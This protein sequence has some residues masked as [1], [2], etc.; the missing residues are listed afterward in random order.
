MILQLAMQREEVRG[1]ADGLLQTSAA[2]FKRGYFDDGGNGGGSGGRRVGFNGTDEEQRGYFDGGNGVGGRRMGCNETNGGSRKNG[3]LNE[4]LA[5]IDLELNG[6]SNES[7]AAR[8]LLHLIYEFSMSNLKSTVMGMSLEYH[9][10]CC[11]SFTEFGLK[12]SFAIAVRRLARGQFTHESTLGTLCEALEAALSWPFDEYR[13]SSNDAALKMTA[14]IYANSVPMDYR[15]AEQQMRAVARRICPGSTWSQLLT[16]N[17]DF[18]QSLSKAYGEANSVEV[19]AKIRQVLLLLSAL[20]GDVFDND[21][22]ASSHAGKMAQVGFAL[23]EGAFADV[24]AFRTSLESPTDE[25]DSVIAGQV[26][27]ACTIISCALTSSST[28][29]LEANMALVERLLVLTLKICEACRVLQTDYEKSFLLEA[30][31]SLH[32]VWVIWTSHVVSANGE[33]PGAESTLPLPIKNAVLQ[34]SA[35]VFSAGVETKLVGCRVVAVC[36]VN[37]ENEGDE[38]SDDED[39]DGR[40]GSLSERIDDLASIGRSNPAGTLKLLVQCLL[41]CAET[42][43]DQPNIAIIT[44]IEKI[45]FIADLI[46]RVLADPCDESEAP[47]MPN[48]I[49]KYSWSLGGNED[50]VVVASYALLNVIRREQENAIRNPDNVSPHFLEKLLLAGNRWCGTYLFP[51][52]SLYGKHDNA[53]ASSAALPIFVKQCFS[54]PER[55]LEVLDYLTRAASTFLVMFGS[56]EKVARAAI[57]LLGT[58][59]ANKT[60]LLKSQAWKE[61]RIANVNSCQNLDWSPL[62][63]LSDKSHAE[64]VRVIGA[65]CLGPTQIDEL[66]FLPMN[67]RLQLIRDVARRGATLDSGWCAQATRISELFRGLS[68]SSFMG[69]ASVL[70]RRRIVS[71]LDDLSF[72]VDV[73][74]DARLAGGETVLLSVLGTF[75]EF[76]ESQLTFT[77]SELMP[78]VFT[79]TARLIGAFVKSA[80]VQQNNGPS[81]SKSNGEEDSAEM[82]TRAERL[83]LALRILIALSERNFLD[84]SSSST[85]R[86]SQQGFASDDLVRVGIDGTELGN[87]SVEDAS[88]VV[89]SC[90]DSVLPLVDLQ[91]LHFAKVVDSYFHLVSGMC[92]TRPEYV[93]QLSVDLFTAIAKSLLFG[94]AYHDAKIQRWSFEAI[95]SLVKTKR[96]AHGVVAEFITKVIELVL[97]STDSAAMDSAADALFTMTRFDTNLFQNAAKL[98]VTTLSASSA[99]GGG[100]DSQARVLALVG[101]LENLFSNLF[102]GFNLQ[103]DPTR[104]DR[105]KFATHMTKLAAGVRPFIVVR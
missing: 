11:R 29:T 35:R 67:A 96:L 27:D 87:S 6:G 16:S 70:L 46:G 60:Q 8:L 7:H 28:E 2:L 56:E 14:G 73:S 3:E 97:A 78:V 22:A 43:N 71:S 94:C 88:L 51:D 50:L 76:F 61:A 48:L 104:M 1:V 83:E 52:L 4:L 17:D 93:A 42:S 15:S 90:I 31:L 54:D 41:E 74:K 81:P 36:E 79:S 105:K 39:Q 49:L 95:T 26:I 57:K 103:I 65:S 101:A 9:R 40:G 32:N 44:R 86:P 102:Q 99:M 98:I 85:S 38:D 77:E 45:T 33:D 64:L 20:S 53:Y 91:M 5:T 63:R 80:G 92:R 12:E 55:A 66:C 82:E 21:Q 59:G 10:K 72:C 47:T 19:K 24:Q 68:K 37:G 34:A 84:F 58:L 30:L 18:L 62:N 13:A 69:D 25:S 23:C 89:L 75:A 100:A